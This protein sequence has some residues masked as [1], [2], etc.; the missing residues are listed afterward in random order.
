M[1][2]DR[3]PRLCSIHKLK[4]RVVVKA[5]IDSDTAKKI[6]GLIKQAR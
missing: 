6:Q 4:Q 2:P 3:N 5:G 1:F